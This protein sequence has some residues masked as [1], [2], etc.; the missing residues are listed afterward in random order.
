MELVGK[1]NNYDWGKLGTQSEAAKLAALNSADFNA[2]ENV[3]YSELWMG[4]HPSGPSVIKSSKEELGKFIAKNNGT[5]IIGG[6]DKLPFLFKVL[7]IRKA[8][9]IQVHPNKKEAERLFV[10]RPEVFKDPNHK[11]EIAIA[12]TP[13]VA[14]CGFRTNED[15]QE[16]CQKLPPLEELLGSENVK[17]LQSGSKGLRTCFESLMNSPVDRTNACI[18]AIA[19]NYTSV[20]QE[21]GML[22]MFNKI[23]KDFPGDSGLLALFFVNL[24]RLQPGEAIFLAANE[25]H[26]YLEGDCIEC[27]S[28]SDNVVR[29][30]LTPK[31]KDIPCLIQMLNFEGSPPE[32]NL[33]KP[34]KVD[35]CLERFAPPIEDFAVDKL[36]IPKSE[37]EYKLKAEKY[38]GI[39][40]VLNGE[41][42]LV[43]ANGDELAVTRGSIVFI[44]GNVGDSLT[45]KV[46][47][48]NGSDFQG[49]IAKYNSYL[50]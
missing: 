24:I 10:E 45:L 25:I 9:S 6:L 14:L 48:G 36:S 31:L 33:F 44:P 35:E 40:L 27:M 18:E 26:A 43:F 37:K 22:D 12:L 34:I 28:C 2:D 47:E 17:L 29:A 1:V 20:L 49:Y 50:N 3:P 21:R 46:K 13:F 42:Q 32:K 19:N 16:L 5:G 15:I 30:G 38:G 41:R 39:L 8:L 4:D 11:P 7:S 23:K